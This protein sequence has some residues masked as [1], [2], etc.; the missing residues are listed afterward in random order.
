MNKSVNKLR[1]CQSQS[2][3]K[4]TGGADQVF[5]LMRGRAETSGL[6]LLDAETGSAKAIAN[7]YKG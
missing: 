5:A 4:A 7:Y 1:T 6:V 3:E 2:K